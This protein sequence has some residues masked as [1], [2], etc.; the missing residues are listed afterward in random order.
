MSRKLWNR[1]V[2]EVAS[3]GRSA[4]AGKQTGQVRFRMSH[5]VRRT[6]IWLP[7]SIGAP[8]TGSDFSP[9]SS[10]FRGSG[11]TSPTT[12]S[13]TFRGERPRDGGAQHLSRGRPSGRCRPGDCGRNNPAPQNLVRAP[14]RPFKERDRAGCQAHG[15]AWAWERRVP[16]DFVGWSG[17]ADHD[18]TVLIG[19]SATHAHARP[20]HGA[21]GA[22]YCFFCDSP[23][24]THRLAAPP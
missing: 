23:F 1:W 7:K 21:Q 6:P 13:G 18:A 22:A 5:G 2:I 4:V 11:W 20:W 24:F 8:R 15:F 10:V 9:P 16:A 17:V 14:R 19:C 12:A 3:A